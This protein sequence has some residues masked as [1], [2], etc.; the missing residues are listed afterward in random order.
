MG[1]ASRIRFWGFRVEGSA[2]PQPYSLSTKQVVRIWGLQL[3]VIGFVGAEVSG[4][5]TLS[6][7]FKALG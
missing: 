6:L 5:Q 1:F 3:K 7:V 4:V 2:V